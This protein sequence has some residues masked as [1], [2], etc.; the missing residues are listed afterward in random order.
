MLQS[1]SAGQVEKAL[2]SIHDIIVET[3]Q[4]RLHP[5]LCRLVSRT[6]EQK[7]YKGKSLS[8]KKEVKDKIVKLLEV[9]NGGS[10]DE[11]G[12]GNTGKVIASSLCKTS[13]TGATA[14][15]SLKNIGE[16]LKNTGKTFAESY[17]LIKELGE[18]A[19][20][21][22]YEGKHRE[23]KERVAIKVMKKEVGLPSTEYEEPDS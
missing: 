7:T 18:G 16:E 4:E 20:S 5:T 12:E 23:T 15:E 1:G 17:K 14:S 10:N 8:S 19:F 11:S 2:A 9:V 6:L 3:R 13:M 22:V 21:I